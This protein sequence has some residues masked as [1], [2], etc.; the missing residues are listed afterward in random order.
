MALMVGSDPGNGNAG[1]PATWRISDS[2]IA[3]LCDRDCYAATVSAGG[4]TR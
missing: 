3:R 1:L 4:T 2:A